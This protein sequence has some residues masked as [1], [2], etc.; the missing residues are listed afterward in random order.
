MT[1]IPPTH[2]VSYFS[3]GGISPPK[4]PVATGLRRSRQ[5]FGGAKDFYP[6]FPKLSRKVFVTIVFSRQ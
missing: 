3:L 5:I 6:N 2:S 1:K 4:L